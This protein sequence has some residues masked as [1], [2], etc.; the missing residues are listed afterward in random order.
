MGLLEDLGNESNFPKTKRAWCSVCE[1][2]SDLT[3]KEAEMLKARM[4]LKHIT[5]VAISEVLKKNG[6]EI[7]DSTIGRHRRGVCQGVAK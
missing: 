3:D 6:Y 1:L 4:S 7:S 2:F 5:H